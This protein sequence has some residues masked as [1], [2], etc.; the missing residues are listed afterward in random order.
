VNDEVMSDDYA[1]LR[2]Q[3]IRANQL[4]LESLGLGSGLGLA[5]NS[6]SASRKER[7]KPRIE[8]RRGNDDDDD[9]DDDYDSAQDDDDDDNLSRKTLKREPKAAR[10]RVRRAAPPVKAAVDWSAV[11][12]E[13]KASRGSA[14]GRP[15]SA[16]VDVLPVDELLAVPAPFAETKTDAMYRLVG[17]SRFVFGKMSGI[18]QFANA[19]ALFVNIDDDAAQRRYDNHYDER[20]LHWYAQTRQTLETPVIQ[21][22][23]SGASDV[24]LLVKMAGEYTFV[25]R[26]GVTLLD[27]SKQPI[28]FRLQLRDRAM[29]SAVGRE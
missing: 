6:G 24:L 5:V 21:R 8:T 10:M 1:T 18:Q 11:L 15:S 25:G 19:V 20:V 16:L 14:T 7:K 9:D 22:I 3:K 28:S 26:V 23:M 4:Y 27:A 2:L 29:P 12:E 17:H 13:R